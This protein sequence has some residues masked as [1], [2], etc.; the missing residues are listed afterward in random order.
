M[1]PEHAL[2][3]IAR[4]DAAEAKVARVEALLGRWEYQDEPRERR[5]K[6]DVTVKFL[7]TGEEMGLTSSNVLS[8]QS[9]ATR[10][11]NATRCS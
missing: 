4:A 7:S 6:P 1:E 3:V 9:A 11:C 5:S 8:S 10:L 2:E